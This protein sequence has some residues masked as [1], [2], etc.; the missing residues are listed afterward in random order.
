MIAKELYS[1]LPTMVFNE[2]SEGV[3]SKNTPWYFSGVAHDT[4]EDNAYKTQGGFSHGVYNDIDG[5]LSPSLYSACYFALLSALSA[6]DI[7]ISKL[8]RIRLGLNTRTDVPVVN[9]SHIDDDRGHTVALL[10]LNTTDGNTLL[11]GSNGKVLTEVTPE[12]NKMVVFDGSI[13]HS[14]QTPTVS[15]RRVT[16]N[17]NFIK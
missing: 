8:L 13:Y 6:N 7:S 2:L 5:V 14:S 17:Y 11:Y 10:Y 9:G 3:L 16:I 12:K 15:P 1:V 4:E